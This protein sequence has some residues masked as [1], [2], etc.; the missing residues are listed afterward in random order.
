VKGLLQIIN[1]TLQITEVFNRFIAIVKNIN[2]TVEITEDAFR[3]TY[4]LAGVTR[5]KDQSIL[6]N[7]RCTLMKHD[8]GAESVRLYTI[9]ANVN[10]DGN[11]DFDFTG[12][13]DDQ[14]RYLVKAYDD[15]I[16]DARGVSNEDLEPV[17]E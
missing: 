6:P 17:L 2:E 13:I 14:D 10:S 1:D 3:P 15:Q 4:H 9:V 11:G 8:G 12:L 5:A 7:C 16:E